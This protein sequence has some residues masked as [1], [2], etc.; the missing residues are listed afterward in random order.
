MNTAPSSTLSSGSL[1]AASS[2]DVVMAAAQRTARVAVVFAGIVLALMVANAVASRSEDPAKATRLI[3]LQHQLTLHP[4]DEALRAR[5]RNEDK[6]VRQDYL[7]HRDFA[8]RGAWLMLAATVVYLL[9]SEVVRR[10]QPQL[11]A[12]R[13]DAATRARMAAEATFRSV[14]TVGGILAGTLATLSVLARHD[15]LAEYARA[16][17]RSPARTVA[18][19]QSARDASNA[20]APTAP[21]LP[22]ASASPQAAGSG[23]VAQPEGGTLSGPGTLLVPMPTDRGAPPKPAAAPELAKKPAPTVRA[24]LAPGWAENWPRFRGPEGTGVALNRKPPIKWDGAKGENV[25]WKTAI[26]LP[27]WNSPIVWG[28][29]I[30][31]SGATAERREVY[32][33]DL[34]TGAI[35]WRTAIPLPAGVPVPKVQAD[36]GY[37]PSTLATDGA[38]ICAMFVTGDVACLDMNGKLLWTR[39]FGP[40]ENP[41]G[42]ATSLVIFGSGLIL[43]LDQGHGDDGKSVLMAL[44]LVSGKTVWQIKRDVGASWSTPIVITVNGSEQLITTASPRVIA[45]DPH[46]GKEIWRADVL[47]GEVAISPVFGPGYVLVANQGSNSAAIRPDSAGDVTKTAVLWTGGDGLPDIASPVVFGNRMLLVMTEGWL[48]CVH[49]TTGK[50]A[51]DA[52]IA[53]TVRSSPVL[54]DGRIYLT[55]SDGVTHIMEAGNAFKLL[56]KCPLGEEV[57]ASP[58]FVGSRIIIRGKQ[59]L[60]CI[61]AK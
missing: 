6:R 8:L 34:D 19:A 35:V 47:G 13:P 39:S 48:T 57:N 53:T 36:T 44:D 30:F 9:A 12:P 37:A 32:A 40:L 20:P 17:D 18:S 50:P 2:E 54:A 1:N 43:Q 27:G 26:P 56:A 15:S 4:G 23:S 25:L 58:A 59:H 5:V 52:D 28:N 11:P 41:Y 46:N 21:G 29:R 61:G 33:V 55:A 60:Y 16:A 45:Y 49:I 24:S 38:R 51:W 10:R 14:V 3:E 31:L 22:I 7:R 42:H